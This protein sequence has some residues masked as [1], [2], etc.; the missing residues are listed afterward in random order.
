MA[1]NPLED[2]SADDAMKK[3]VAAGQCLLPLSPPP[4]PV[5][6]DAVLKRLQTAFQF[7]TSI[8]LAAEREWNARIAKLRTE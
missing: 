6:I 1:Y 3:I 5:E 7:P 2:W 4:D 8:R